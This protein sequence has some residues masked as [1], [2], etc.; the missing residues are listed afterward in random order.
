[1][2][3]IGVLCALDSPGPLIRTF[4]TESDLPGPLFSPRA[5]WLPL[6]LQT[7]TAFTVRASFPLRIDRIRATRS[8]DMEPTKAT[9]IP[10]TKAVDS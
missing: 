10:S 4:P 6:D 3:P 7:D 8:T 1:M 9:C 2:P 5:T